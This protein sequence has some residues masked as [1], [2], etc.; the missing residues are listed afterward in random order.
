[1]NI[2][3][4]ETLMD[5]Y[6]DEIFDRCHYVVKFLEFSDFYIFHHDEEK[7]INGIKGL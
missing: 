7:V 1:M 6:L 4:D 2:I 5:K 3:Y